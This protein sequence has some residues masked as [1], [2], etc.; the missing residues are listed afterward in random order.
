MKLINK[1]L[2][3]VGVMLI[4]HDEEDIG[5]VRS[6]HTGIPLVHHYLTG[7][8]L[9]GVGTFRE[10]IRKLEVQDNEQERR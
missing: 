9:Y 8:F 5:K 10:E 6:D 3:A 7:V 4:L 2:Q 1:I